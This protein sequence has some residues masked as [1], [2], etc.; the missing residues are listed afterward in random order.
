MTTHIIPD[1]PP[2]PSGPP[3]ATI[4]EPPEPEPVHPAAAGTPE[5]ETF[6]RE[7]VEELRREAAQYRTRARDYDQAFEGYDDESREALLQYVQLSYR[8]NNGDADAARQLEEMFGGDDDDALSSPADPSSLTPEPD[9]RQ[10]AR[11]EA[12]ALL[13][14]REA[15]RAQQEG[16]DAVRRAGEELGYE[17]GTE[18][19]ILFVRGAHEA[20][21]A[22]NDDPIAAGDAAV[23]AYH[24]AVVERF[25][26]EKG[27]QA[28]TGLQLPT[29]A[30]TAPN[31]TTRPWTDE[32]SESARWAAVAKSAEERLRQAQ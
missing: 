26:A 16:I 3:P 8:A 31:L 17:F 30:G 25:L 6:P 2:E 21:T 11:E 18:D 10:I 7:Y 15:E 28:D 4:D 27:Q 12:Q 9:Y 32:M 5:P 24:Q 14:A 1:E 22:G 13:D 19:Y 20:V 23:K 29:G